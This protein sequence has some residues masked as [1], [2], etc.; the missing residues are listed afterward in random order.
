MVFWIGAGSILFL[1][2]LAMLWPLVFPKPQAMARASYDVQVYKDQ[3]KE[4]DTDLARGVLSKDEAKASRV[5]I[6]RRLLAADDAAGRDTVNPKAPQTLSR[7]LGIGIAVAVVF[8]AFGLYQKIGVPGLPDL[9]LNER[10]S[11]RPSQVEAELALAR[12]ESD[13]TLPGLQTADPKHLELVIQLQSVLKDRPDDLVG[14]R[15]LADNLAQLGQYAKARVA[16]DTVMR[17]LGGKAGAPDYAS[18]GEIMVIAANWY[19]SPEAESALAKALDLDPK[20]QR[21]RYYAGILMLQRQDYGR[22]YQLWSEL[23]AE[24]PMDAP[25]IPLIKNQIDAVAAE[26]GITQAPGPS[27]SDVDNAANMSAEERRDMIRAMVAQLSER[28]ATKGGS[29]DEWARL[30]RAYGVLG[31]TAKAS[32]IW[33]EAQEVFANDNAAIALLL[34]AARDAEV[35]AR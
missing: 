9:P 17:I 25:W 29:A 14:Y 30:I 6:S 15:M 16:Q 4:L 13:T 20:N 26:A 21:A 5:E 18:L 12:I 2:L 11:Q 23:L 34:Q 10:S 32:A 8:S 35:S 7:L 33:N 31:E 24:G 22:A 3:L 19:V 28:L 27:A 1:A